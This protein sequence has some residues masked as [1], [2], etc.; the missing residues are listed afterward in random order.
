VLKQQRISWGFTQVE[1][2]VIVV[3]AGVLAAIAASTWVSFFDN[4]ALTTAQNTIYRSLQTAKDTARRR[5][6]SW[7]VSFREQ[8]NQVQWATHAASQ[9]PQE[10]DWQTLDTGIGISTD[11][12][13]YEVNGLYQVKFNR[14][15]H[16]SPRLGR[17]TIMSRRSTQNQ[18]CVVIS[19][20]L[21]TM[22]QA[23]GAACRPS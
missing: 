20:L 8:S 21:G 23:Q 2:L 6:L 9:S 1:L 17:I 10:A 16:P 15:G 3:I 5:N 11:S 7:Q 22:R 13:L 4:M 19:T 12:T 14:Q 18:R